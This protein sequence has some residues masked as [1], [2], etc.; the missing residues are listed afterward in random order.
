[1]NDG[2]WVMYALLVVT[3]R[4]QRRAIT[5]GVA[6]LA[7]ALLPLAL[8]QLGLSSSALSAEESI[9]RAAPR[10]RELV[11]VGFRGEGL[12]ATAWGYG[13]AA[14]PSFLGCLLLGLGASRLER[15][16]PR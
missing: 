7:C 14:F 11:R 2:G 6:M 16:K 5:F 4:T 13:A 12:H 8:G 3:L 9:T 10:Y 1:M 15:F